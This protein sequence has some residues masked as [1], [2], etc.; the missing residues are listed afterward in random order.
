MRVVERFVVGRRRTEVVRKHFVVRAFVDAAL[1]QYGHRNGVGVVRI[2]VKERIV[3]PD[4]G[5]FD[6]PVGDGLVRGF[7]DVVLLYRGLVFYRTQGAQVEALDRRPFQLGLEFGLDDR[8]VD[9]VVGQFV[10]DVEACVVP[11]VEFVGIERAR[12]V[13]RVGVGVDV[14]LALHLARHVVCGRRQGSRCLL[15]TIGTVGNQV[16]RQVFEDVVGG[17]D[18]GRVAFHLAGLRPSRVAHGAQ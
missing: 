12:R 2:G 3:V 4:G 8:K 1:G 10:Q 17:V 16:Q 7:G 9:V 13:E 15:F 5:R 14:E 18:V 6:G 11:R